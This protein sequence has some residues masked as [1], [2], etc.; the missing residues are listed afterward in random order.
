MRCG[1]EVG[2]W[3]GQDTMADLAGSEDEAVVILLA[4]LLVLL[5]LLPAQA[6]CHWTQR[7]VYPKVVPVL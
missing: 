5:Q 4:V 1:A 7:L 2:V 3:E 6:H